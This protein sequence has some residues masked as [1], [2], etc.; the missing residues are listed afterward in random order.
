MGIFSLF[1][2]RNHQEVKEDDEIEYD[3]NSDKLDK[4][5]RHLVWVFVDNK[6]LQNIII[7]NGLAEIKYIYGEYMYTNTLENSLNIAKENKIGMWQDSDSTNY[8]LII[9]V[10]VLI[11]IICL[12]SSKYRKKIINK[13]KSNIKKNIKKEFKNILK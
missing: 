1:K 8:T 7:Q 4:Y 2:K 6:L 9:I 10:I 13:T 12:F 3:P 11:V 5:N